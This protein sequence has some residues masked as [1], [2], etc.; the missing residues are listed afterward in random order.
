MNTDRSKAVLPHEYLEKLYPHDGPEPTLKMFIPDNIH[1]IKNR[2]KEKYSKLAHTLVECE[3][4][5]LSENSQ[6]YYKSIC[7][8]VPVREMYKIGLD[9]RKQTICRNE[10]RK[11]I[12]KVNQ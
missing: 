10:I 3:V 8:G 12:I 11:L 7:D 2:A 5:L 9:F 4:R 6:K 1:N